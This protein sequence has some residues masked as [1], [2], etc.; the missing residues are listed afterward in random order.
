[1]KLTVSHPPLP[2]Q[3][4]FALIAAIFLLVVLSALGVFM[5]SISTSHHAGQ[6]LDLAGARAYQAARA[7]IEWSAFQVM[8]PENADF[9]NTTGTYTPQYTCA[10]SPVTWSAMNGT[11]ANYTVVVSC[12]FADHSDGGVQKRV[13]TLISTATPTGVLPGSLDFVERQIT[14]TLGTCRQTTDGAPC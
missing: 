13:Y 7:G 11:L 1:M 2:H 5:V 8:A 9:G 3:H 12:S 14:A 6:M 4:G 10:G